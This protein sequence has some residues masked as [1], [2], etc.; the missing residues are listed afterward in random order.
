[1]SKFLADENIFPAIVRFL[2]E[3]G[4]DVK[5]LREAGLLGAKDEEIALFALREKRVLVTFDKHFANVLLYPPSKY[6]GIIVIRIHPPLLTDIM[7]ALD[8]FLQSFN[9]A[10]L[11]RVLVVLERR[12]FRVRKTP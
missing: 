12:G 8:R 7:D 10:N 4:F 1:V 6:H 3:K 9:P 11:D 2:R 5:D